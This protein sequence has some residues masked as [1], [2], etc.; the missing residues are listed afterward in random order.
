MGEE[1]KKYYETIKDA[2]D[3]LSDLYEEQLSSLSDLY[4]S[5]KD[6]KEQYAD[7]SEELLDSIEEADKQ[8][9][10]KLEKINTSLG[11]A[12]KD[13]LDEVKNKLDERRRQEDNKKQE[14]DISKKQQRLAAL[15][16]NTAGG[17]QVEIAQLQKEIADAQQSYGRSL[18]DQLLDKLQK[19][20]D[21]AA[22]QRERQIEIL[23]AQLEIS[24]ESGN[25][26]AL[27]NEYLRDPERYKNEIYELWKAGKEYDSQTDQRKDVL[28]DDWALFWKDIN[29]DGLSQE[30][31]LT[32]EAITS[33]EDSLKQV[34]QALDALADT[35]NSE[36]TTEKSVCSGC[37]ARA[38]TLHHRYHSCDRYLHDP[39]AQLRQ[40]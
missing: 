21:E 1:V 29:S 28:D 7:R 36:K 11:D 9:V 26:V 14:E 33:V 38:Q 35:L 13:L 27:V 6:L 12:L 10:E 32:T 15:R 31:A 22:K 4:D 16:A 8:E 23:N 37:F 19:Q 3:K 17:K 18:E 39:A 34:K 20:A 40:L 5:L 24:K 30:I 25:N 2:S